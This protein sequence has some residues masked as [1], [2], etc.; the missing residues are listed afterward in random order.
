[1]QEFE[2]KESRVRARAATNLAFLNMLEAH[3]GVLL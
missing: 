2:K 1:M 3:T